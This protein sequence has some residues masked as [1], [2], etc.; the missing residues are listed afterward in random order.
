M[1]QKPTTIDSLIEL[2]VPADP[3]ISPDGR[4][5]AYI[6]TEPD[7]KENVFINQIWL[8]KNKA[9][10][11]PRQLT[12]SKQG[13]STPRWSPDSN[14]LAF[15]SKREGDENIQVY[16]LAIHGGEAERLTEIKTDIQNIQWSPDGKSIA[17][18]AIPPQTPQQKDREEKYG[19]FIEDNVDYKRCHLWL[20]SLEDKKVRQLTAGNAV[21]V[22]DFTWHPDS[23]HIGFTGMPSPDMGVLL[24]T[25]IYLLNMDT[26]TTRLLTPQRTFKPVWSPDGKHL[27]YERGEYENLA[28]AF[29]KNS[30]LEIYTLADG[31]IA[32]I[33][34]DFD[35]NISPVTWSNEGIYFSAI[36]G[37]SIHLFQVALDSGAV[38][39]ITPVSRDGFVSMQ[40]SFSEDYSQCGLVYTDSDTFWEVAAIDLA[41]TDFKYL[42]RCYNDQTEAWELPR[43]ESYTWQSTDGTTIEGVLTRPLDFDPAQKYPLL[44]VIHGGP[45]W[46]SL[47]TR[48]GNNARRLYPIY[49]WVAQG[50]LV[51]EPNYRGS[52]GYGE[53]FRALNVRDLGTG[54]YADVISGVDALIAEGWI[55]EHRVGAMGWSQGGYISA[56]ITTYSDRF[57]AVSVGA[58]ISNWM[59]YYVNTDIHPFTINYLQA[60]PWDDPEIYAKTSP[61]TYIKRAKTPTLIQHGEKDARVPLPNAFELHQGLLDQGVK[62]KLI[63]YPGMPHGPIKPKQIRHIMNDNFNFFNHYIFG[64]ESEDV[65]SVPLYIVVPAAEENNTLVVDVADLARRDGT[66]YCILASDGTLSENVSTTTGEIAIGDISVVIGRLIEQ[67][68]ALGAKKIRVYTDKSEHDNSVLVVLGCIQIAAGYIGKISIEHH[69]GEV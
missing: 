21:H 40:Y 41:T 13:S 24:E 52:A 12:F 53:T 68:R 33:H 28:G 32:R 60:T 7:W 34:M 29:Y 18:S 63:V 17:F 54:D 16:R 38:T 66:N 65:E 22:L 39:Q 55:D 50:A 64:I 14:Y 48:A 9:D 36:R 56:F 15:L 5:I 35:E 58:G 59:T 27:V 11:E 44:I 67:L 62:S 23:K 19:D 30:Y 57:K 2:K 25:R 4:G 49:Q 31:S 8:V 51:L 43:H 37:M 42:T 61:I 45:T 46:I 6:V 26:L 20:V 1:E 69:Q 10:V 3:R 47:R